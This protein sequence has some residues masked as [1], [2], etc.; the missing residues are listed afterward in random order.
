MKLAA[1]FALLVFAIVPAAC[2]DDPTLGEAEQLETGD[3]PDP[4]EVDPCDQDAD[5][6]PSYACGGCDLDDTDPE[7]GE[8]PDCTIWG[9]PSSLCYPPPP[10]R[11]RTPR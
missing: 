9:C 5:G 11:P 8:D 10:P 6:I 7:L 2:V 4:P 1:V 3:D